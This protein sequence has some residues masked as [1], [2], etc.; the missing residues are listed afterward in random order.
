VVLGQRGGDL[1]TAG[2]QAAEQLADRLASNAAYRRR[3]ENPIRAGN[4]PRPS[5]GS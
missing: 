2:L 4:T 1:L 3:I 5:L